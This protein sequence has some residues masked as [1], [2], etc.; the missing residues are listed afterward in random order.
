MDKVTTWSHQQLAIYRWFAKDQA[1]FDALGL[2]IAIDVEGNLVVVA[3]AGCGKTT[4]ILEAINYAPEQSIALCAFNNRIAKELSDRLNNPRAIAKTLHGIGYSFVYAYLGRTNVD[5]RFR[6]DALTDQIVG[7]NAPIKVKRHITKLHTLA[8]EVTPL[9]TDIDTIV[10]LAGNHDL[11]AEDD[12]VNMGFDDTM[13]AGFVLDIMKHASTKEPERG[14]IDYADMIFL[15]VRNKWLRQKFDLVVVDETQ[16]MNNAQLLIVKGICKGRT[17]VVGD[18][19]QAI[20][21]FRGADSESMSRL[22]TELRAGELGLT[23]TYRCGKAI[24]RQAAQLVPDFMAG[25][26]NPDGLVRQVVNDVAMLKEV[27]YGDFVLSRKNAPIA[28][29]AMALLREKRRVAVAGRDIGAGLI[30][31]VDQLCVGKAVNSIPEFLAK[32]QAWQEKEINRL[33]R[34]RK[35]EKIDAVVDK[36]ETLF[37]LTEGVV[38]VSELKARLEGLFTDIGDPA[39][40]VTLSSV[41]KAKGLEANRVYVLM[42]T[43]YPRLPKGVN[44]SEKARIARQREESNIEYV[45]LTRAKNELVY[46]GQRPG[47]PLLPFVAAEPVTQPEPIPVM[48]GVP[49]YPDECAAGANLGPTHHDPD[50]HEIHRFEDEGGPV[51]IEKEEVPL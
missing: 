11:E 8:R 51:S 30:K 24:V 22:K 7:M 28:S 16:D 27:A 14:L 9:A 43:L 25:P 33:T 47:G 39:T 17:V 50:P 38:G 35:E 36:A 46:V 32:L 5:A 19:R 37:V 4:T 26:N 2:E 15:P 20:Y 42:E 29:L 34:S 23:T 41:H 1:Y 21:G 48:A 13:I 44:L 18:D 10:D 12:W 6:G 31:L 3:R 49:V 40:R 45:A